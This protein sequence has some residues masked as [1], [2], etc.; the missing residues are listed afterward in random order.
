MGKYAINILGIAFLSDLVA[1]RI[2]LAIAELIWAITLFWPGDTFGRPTYAIMN[3]IFPKEEVW[4]AIW[5]FS[6]MTQF[7]IVFK[8]KFHEPVAITFA[9]FNSIF[10]WFSVISMY[11]SV[12]PP[13]A[14]ISGETALAVGAAWVWVRS[15]WAIEHNYHPED[16]ACHGSE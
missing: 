2:M 6:S 14:A 4:A 1:T 10:W 16:K 8:R 11:L 5:L 12:T 15:G 13:P 7:W 9:A 3:H